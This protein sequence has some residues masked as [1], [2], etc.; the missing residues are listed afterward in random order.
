MA[1]AAEVRRPI[2][3]PATNV[4]RGI[5]LLTKV[6]LSHERP[7]LSSELFN[8]AGHELN[9][10]LVALSCGISVTSISVK[11]EGN[12]LGRTIFAGHIS[13]ETFK[14][15]AA[16]GSVCA[17]DGCAWG[18]GHDLYQVDR[19]VLIHGG[20]SRE[21]AQKDASKILNTFNPAVRT[22]AAEI[23]AFLGE[24]SGSMLKEV[25]KRA[26]FEAKIAPQDYG[27]ANLYGEEKVRELS[28]I[29]YLV[30]DKYRVRYF[31]E[32]RLI[33]EKTMCATCQAEHGHYQ[34]CLLLRNVTLENR[35][36]KNDIK[37][38]GEIIVKPDVGKEEM[39][40]RDN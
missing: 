25:L 8:T 14:V 9:H 3:M 30:G 24:I 4:E 29:E 32:G 26:E 34:T 2:V 39:I 17:H 20:R 16:A 21:S 19:A 40:V 15:I 6:P 7:Q 37:G 23:L 5:P 31:A 12:S 35:Y 18:F 38:Y 27:I 10:A 33:E 36:G 22:K 1:A 11:P 28:S 13:P